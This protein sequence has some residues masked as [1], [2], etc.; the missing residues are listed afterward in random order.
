MRIART[1]TIM[2]GHIVSVAFTVVALTGPA[3]ADMS[4]S[5]QQM[6]RSDAIHPRLRSHGRSSQHPKSPEV[7]T[8]LI[9]KDARS[10][11]A[12][13]A[14]LRRRW[15]FR[16]DEMFSEV[17]NSGLYRD[18]ILVISSHSPIEASR[19]CDKGD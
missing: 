5:V 9:R 17:P 14:A 12:P 7:C 13:K 18:F 4:R 11:Y 10:R 19:L 2:D 8:S 16:V 15:L 1:V 6:I 3:V